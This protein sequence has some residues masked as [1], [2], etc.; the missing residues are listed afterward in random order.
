KLTIIDNDK[1]KN[2]L[3]FVGVEEKG[4]SENELV[5]YIKDLLIDAGIHIDSQEISNVYRIGQKID[6]KQRPVVVSI[7]TR[8][9]QHTILKYRS[10]L[11]D[12]IYVNEDYP[13]EVMEIRK[14]LLPQMRA[15]REKGNIAYIK[16]NKLVVKPPEPAADKN[17]ERKK[18]N[19]SQSPNTPSQKKVNLDMEQTQSLDKNTKGTIKPSIL[20]YIERSKTGS[21][22]EAPK[23]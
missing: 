12:G 18:R 10:K 13:K 8:W 15:E 7:T 1:R 11:P 20:T 3:V 16:N 5:D 21:P 23:N 2:N 9:K 19:F 4:K 14:Q 22:I 6:N 17:R